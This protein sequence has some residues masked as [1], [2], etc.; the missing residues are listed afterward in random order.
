MHV[1]TWK[2]WIFGVIN[3]CKKKGNK[4]TRPH[5]S[6]SFKKPD[7]KIFCQFI[8]EVKLPDGFGSNISKKVVDNDTNIIGLKS[9]D[10]HIL[11]QRLL[12]IGVKGLLGKGVYTPIIELGMFFKQLC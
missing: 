5:A 3:G 10:Y 2:I 1:R 4:F 9:H 6:Y 12:P 11:M 7:C 8:R